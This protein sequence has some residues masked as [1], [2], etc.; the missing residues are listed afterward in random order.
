M[1]LGFMLQLPAPFLHQICLLLTKVSCGHLPS[2]VYS[3]VE[4][5]N[6]NLVPGLPS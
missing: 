3:L 5:E 6:I 4:Q 1:W 2:G